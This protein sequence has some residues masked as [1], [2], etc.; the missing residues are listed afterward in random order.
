MVH[1]RGWDDS[2]YVC[3][4]LEILFGGIIDSCNKVYNPKKN[5][6]KQKNDY[7]SLVEDGE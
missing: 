3:F 7:R 1:F 2:T 4:P 6:E 5:Y